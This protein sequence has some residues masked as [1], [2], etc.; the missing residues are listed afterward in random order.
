MII[1]GVGMV[2]CGVRGKGKEGRGG[3]LFAKV[4]E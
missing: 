3:D 1:I 4:C 2:H